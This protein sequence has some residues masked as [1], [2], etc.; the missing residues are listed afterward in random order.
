M[1]PS[2]DLVTPVAPGFSEENIQK[3]VKR[4]QEASSYLVKLC[5]QTIQYCNVP[6]DNIAYNRNNLDGFKTV[7]GFLERDS[8]K[9][10]SVVEF[11][12]GN[13]K[14]KWTKYLLSNPGK[15]TIPG[16]LRPD[17]WTYGDFAEFMESWRKGDKLANK[18]SRAFH[19]LNL[20]K[21]IAVSKHHN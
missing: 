11:F 20:P 4:L 9:W 10:E 15:V 3:T 7:L 16:Y 1:S 14:A 21:N 13:V 2:H 17:I 18:M 5:A 19:A 12:A 6:A 8:D